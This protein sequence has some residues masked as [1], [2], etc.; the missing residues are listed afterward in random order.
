MKTTKQLVQE[1]DSVLLILS[2]LK[3]ITQKL[4]QGS[5]VNPLHLEAILQFLKI[6]V[7][8]NH[9]GKEEKL[10][11][12]LLVSKGIANAGGPVGVMLSEHV[13]GRIFIRGFSDAIDKYR[14]GDRKSVSD[15]IK[16]ANGYVELL[17][18]HIS[19]ENNVLFKMAENKLSV[20][21]DEELNKKFQ[22]L[23][24]S[25][26]GKNKIGELTTML[27]EL[28]ELYLTESKS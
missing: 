6:F 11:F 3:R 15:I 12:P 22:E 4:S 19:K 1:H 16:N 5:E 8:Q 26:V 14:K 20:E 17:Q 21:E 23:E 13:Q 10:F 7:D 27:E 28:K 9:H 18:Q 25:E 2:I 24:E